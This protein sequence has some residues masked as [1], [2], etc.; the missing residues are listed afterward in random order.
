[1]HLWHLC[2]YRKND[3]LCQLPAAGL[4]LHIEKGVDPD[5]RKAFLG[6]AQWLRK[7]FFFPVR[8]NVYI[9]KAY[10]I[11]AKDG[12]LVVGTFWESFAYNAYPY[13]RL[14]TGDYEELKENRGEKQALL[15]ILHSFAHELSHYYQHINA[16]PQ[17]PRGRERQATYYATKI[18]EAYQDH[19]A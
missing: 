13:I 12:E 19:I 1:M 11:Q 5:I 17:T 9:K 16:L 18:V 14:A 3:K 6:F 7:E 8:V 4:R 10:R 15:S 2:E